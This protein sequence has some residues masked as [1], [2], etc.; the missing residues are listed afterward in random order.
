MLFSPLSFCLSG[1]VAFVVVVVV[2]S[3]LFMIIVLAVINVLK[4]VL[5][6]GKT[7]ERY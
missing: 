5:Q 7:V 2:A 6:F 1:C 4:G 3:L